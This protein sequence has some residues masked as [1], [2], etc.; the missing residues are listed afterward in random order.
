MGL[1]LQME[2]IHIP[3]TR[4]AAFTWLTHSQ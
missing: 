4:S 3:R 1:R 2:L